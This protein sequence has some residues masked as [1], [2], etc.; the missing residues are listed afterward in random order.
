MSVYPDAL[1]QQPKLSG[2]L[3]NT[4]L[5]LKL[6]LLN[7]MLG[8]VYTHITITTALSND[9]DSKVVAEN[10]T[11]CT[12]LVHHCVQ[13]L[14]PQLHIVKWGLFMIAKLFQELLKR[15]F[16]VLHMHILDGRQY[17]SILFQLQMY[18]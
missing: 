10:I 14:Q 15:W 11:C 17:F 12:F 2:Q 18:S 9:Y 4:A 16:F 13:V 1:Y 8:N 6:E 3:A 7:T 5:H